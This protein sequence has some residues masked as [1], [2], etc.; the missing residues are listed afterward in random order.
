MSQDILHY[1]IKRNNKY[2]LLETV[3][4]LSDDILLIEGA[5]FIGSQIHRMMTAA[6]MALLDDATGE[7]AGLIAV[8]PLLYKNVYEIHMSNRKV[9]KLLMSIATD[10]ESK[11]LLS[12]V[13]KELIN[14]ISDII[15]AVVLALPIP[16]IDTAGIAFF[17][18]IDGLIIGN[19]AVSV[20]DMVDGFSKN[21]PKLANILKILAYPFGGNVIY[22]GLKNIEKINGEQEQ[23]KQREEEIAMRPNESYSD[24]FVDEIDLEKEKVNNLT[25]L[26]I[27]TVRWQALSGIN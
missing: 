21:N 5:S 3:Q 11:K 23:I 15:N 6:L 14:D 13:R 25:E 18:M 7:V 1:R 10:P 17:N 26:K 20:T 19:G 12:E 9:E 16:M 27:N 22:A 4:V 2:Q 8:L 24:F